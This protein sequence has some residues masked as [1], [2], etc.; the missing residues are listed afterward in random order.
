M[1][2]P[3]L[4]VLGIMALVLVSGCVGSNI[5]TGDV[6]GIEQRTDL[7]ITGFSN[8]DINTRTTEFYGNRLYLDIGNP[9]PDEIDIERVTASYLDDVLV[10]TTES[11]PLPLG[12]S[13]TYVFDFS[14]TAEWILPDL[15]KVPAGASGTGLGYNQA[16][17]ESAFW[18][19]VEVLYDVPGKGLTRQGSRGFVIGG[20]D[21][22]QILECSAASFEVE[23]KK[24]YFGTRVFSVTLRN[25]GNID[26]EIR[27][28]FREDGVFQEVVE[29]F[30]LSYGARKTLEMEGLT[31]LVESVVF[32]SEACP[33]ASQAIS[34]EDIAGV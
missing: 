23:R 13:L 19:D 24:F 6:A 33:G 12:D 26:L 3:L 10:N 11:G 4:P 18:I 22:G 14:R 29:P 31:E 9:N 7:T 34:V 28:L 17:K 5:P 16:G 27:T 21:T 8:L 15:P 25:T 30:I 20:M 2:R 1:A 32:T